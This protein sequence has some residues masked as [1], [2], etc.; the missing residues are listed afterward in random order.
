MTTTAVAVTSPTPPTFGRGFLLG[1]ADT[2][3]ARALLSRMPEHQHRSFQPGA[4][5]SALS[6]ATGYPARHG[7][8]EGGSVPALARGGEGTGRATSAA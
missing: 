5:P 1:H 8:A 7:R 2:P 4:A 6:R 3:A